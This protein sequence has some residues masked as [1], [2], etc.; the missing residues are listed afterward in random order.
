[1][2]ATQAL[3]RPGR[4]S[5]LAAAIR[6]HLTPM[7]GVPAWVHW[8]AVAAAL[9]PVPCTI[10]RLAMGFGVDLGFRGDLADAFAAPGWITLYVI[11]LS[12]VNDAAAYLT[13]GLVR[14]WGQVWPRW[15]PRLGGRAI[16][17]LAVIVPATLGAFSVIYIGIDMLQKWDSPTNMGDPNAPHGLAAKVMASAYLPMLAWGP[18]LAIVT[19]A[20]AIRRYRAGA[21]R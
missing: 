3:S 7:M 4:G 19:V 15:M 17:P 1:M 6:S 9:T 10:W 12:A 16:H 13:M 2:T 20:Y 11:V 18:L 14:P 5:S 8:A 21:G